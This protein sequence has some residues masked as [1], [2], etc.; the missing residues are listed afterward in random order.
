MFPDRLNSLTWS[1]S[2]ALKNAH[3]R[4]SMGWSESDS[5][6]WTEYGQTASNQHSEVTT[7]PFIGMKPIGCATSPAFL[8]IC[9][10]LT[11]FLGWPLNA[12]KSMKTTL[13]LAVVSS[14]KFSCKR[15]WKAWDWRCSR[16]GSKIQRWRGVVRECSQWMCRRILGLRLTTLLVLGWVLSRKKWES[17]LRFVFL[18]IM[19]L[20]SAS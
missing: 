15:W 16:S 13:L 14:S 8:D 9:L 1:S 11:P 10:A 3:T 7:P 4:L 18:S 6:N 12:S 17:T 2:V 19:S 20:I 5:A